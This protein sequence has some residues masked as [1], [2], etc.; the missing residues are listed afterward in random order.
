[1][2]RVNNYKEFINEVKKMFKSEK[3]KLEK[4]VDE[5][6]EFLYENGI[7]DWNGFVAMSS[8][9]RSVVDQLIDSEVETMSD[10]NEIRFLI[11]L[12]L[13]NKKQLETYLKELEEN[14]EYERCSKVSKKINNML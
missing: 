5:I 3:T 2:K 4:C 10:L 6:L 14:E 9:D 11:R 12:E 1:M 8:F 7:K 13:A